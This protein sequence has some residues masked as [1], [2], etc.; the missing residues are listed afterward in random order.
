MNLGEILPA[1]GMMA[2]FSLLLSLK[3]NFFGSFILLSFSVD[4]LFF[5]KLK[6]MMELEL[7]RLVLL[8]FDLSSRLSLKGFLGLGLPLS[9]STLIGLFLE[10]VEIY[11][12]MDMSSS[13][14]LS[15]WFK[16]YRSLLD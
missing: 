10:M 1:S 2:S 9:L 13:I 5:L 3:I 6:V 14:A 7:L 12:S 4:P 16:D 15:S 8:L 11:E